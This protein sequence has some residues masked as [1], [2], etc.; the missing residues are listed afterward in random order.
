[1]NKKNRYLMARKVTLIGAATNALLGIL[2]VIAGVL[3]HS[4]ALVADGIHSFADLIADAMVLFGSKYGSQDADEMH[5]YGH[6]RI[7][8][9]STLFLS[10]M[11]I[12]AGVG[13]GWDAIDEIIHQ[14]NTIPQF[15]ALPV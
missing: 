3:F 14:S 8:T 10:L 12:L 13:I 4:H 15:L 6:Q 2:K 11:L 1:M 7:E 5:P 9:A